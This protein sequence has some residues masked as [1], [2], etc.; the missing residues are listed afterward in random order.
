MSLSPLSPSAVNTKNPLS[1]IIL[2]STPQTSSKMAL[3]PEKPK[4]ESVSPSPQIEAENGNWNEESS[5]PFVT[6]LPVI[7]R[8]VSPSPSAQGTLRGRRSTVEDFSPSGTLTANAQL[9]MEATPFEICEDITSTPPV[10]RPQE[11]QLHQQLLNPQ[12]ESPESSE[13]LDMTAMTITDEE[14]GIDDTCFSTFSE[15]PNVDMTKF[16]RLAN[17]SPSKS[18]YMSVQVRISL[19]LAFREYG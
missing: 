14:A 15:V 3:S 5:S 2:F 11:S 1:P 17:Q 6:E 18:G 4:P 9:R 10:V 8:N 7:E 12:L 16:A 13:L 19:Q